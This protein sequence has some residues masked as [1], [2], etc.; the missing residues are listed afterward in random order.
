MR[1]RFRQ[2]VP[3]LL[4]AALVIAVRWV[5]LD[6]YPPVEAD[7]G[8][9][10]LSVRM[11]VEHGI[12]SDDYYMAPAYH[13]L[14]GLPFRLW[15]PYHWVS[16]PFCA[17][18]AMAGLWMFY[19][20]AVRHAGEDAAF[21]ATLLL[22]TCY[23]A[24]LIDRRA[25][26]EPLQIALMFSVCLAATPAR[27]RWYT[28]LLTAALTG[29]LLLTKASAIFLLPAL[30]LAQLWPWPAGRNEWA[31]RLRLTASLAAGVMAAAGV[32]WV[33]YQSDPVTFLNGWTED[34][35]KVN[36]GTRAA[37]SGRFGFDPLAM[38]QTIRWYGDYEPLL[39]GAGVLG[40]LK[41]LWERRQSLMAAWLVLG[42]VF[43]LIQFYIQENHRVILLA[44]I[45]FLAA[46]LLCTWPASSGARWPRAAL[47]CMVLFSVAR[48]GAG[49]ATAKQP[50]REAVAYLAARTD[51]R[52]K[53][54]AAP[55]VL[56]KLRAQP[57]SFWSLEAPYLPTAEALNR[58]GVEWLMVDPR[59]WLKHHAEAD[60]GNNVRLER[61]L[62]E[63]CDRVFSK[64][65]SSVYRRR[66][67]ASASAHGRQ[68]KP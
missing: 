47:A 30:V 66:G 37:N 50:E 59:E 3:F 51:A 16:R 43:L 21:W 28:Y 39:F 53:V 44:P 26:M 68:L 49:I 6:V 48:L 65:G 17:A 8:G 14:L 1:L 62:A 41:A 55:Y 64:G 52:S 22:G 25:F 29:L 24:V 18:V 36:V 67:A 45:C 9:W 35:S 46:W 19:R 11:W 58:M 38:S 32:F 5:G 63:C 34:M 20:L 40:L 57:V 31:A 27:P 12:R 56:M 10:P 54:M 15:G 13:W 61:A 60:G 23:P 2:S 7:E 33:L 42:G 4:A